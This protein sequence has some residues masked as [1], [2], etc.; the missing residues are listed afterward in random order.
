M[1]ARR[2]GHLR[3]MSVVGSR[4]DCVKSASLMKAYAATGAIEPVLVHT[5][6][7]DR[8][9]AKDV[10]VRDLA[11]PTPDFHLGIG[12]NSDAVE[13]AETMTAF[14]RMMIGGWRSDAVLVLGDANS[15][16]AC[17]LVAAKLRIPVVRVEAGL[18]SSDRS[19]R[20]INR[21]LT[22]T[23]SDLLFCT[24]QADVDN[25]A[26]EGADRD[27]VFLV[28]NV[29]ADTLLANRERAEESS[30][31][32]RLGLDAG[33]YG[34]LTLHPPITNF[35]D[36]PVVT[37]VVDAVDAIQKVL[38]LVVPTSWRL[39]V[40]LAMSG[41]HK[42]VQAMPGV[43]SIPLLGH[44]DFLKLMADAAVV[45][46][47]TRSIQE[48]TTIL[49]V[50]C[51]TLHDNTERPVTVEIGTNQLVG[52]DPARIL[53]AFH[54]V[55]ANPPGGTMPPLWDGKSAGRVANRLVEML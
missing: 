24:E 50:P 36:V 37:Q 14:E 55:L 42:R 32:D 16:I 51:L 19:K 11:I 13:T 17:A 21:V 45:L 26:R 48:E 8:W 22:D 23:L 46:T 33:T 5:G 49:G 15:A 53:A 44:L 9:V 6:R 30:V 40:E 54:D 41:V 27:K 7:H 34:V 25:L 28:G 2:N 10:F 20:E 35:V 31:L 39:M 3:L 38:P 47:D 4:P 52:S 12:P 29:M 43:T 18:R 1:P